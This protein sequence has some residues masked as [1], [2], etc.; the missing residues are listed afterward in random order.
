MENGSSV[1]GGLDHRWSGRSVRWSVIQG[2]MPFSPA[3]VSQSW[4]EASRWTWVRRLTSA[5]AR[6][7]ARA[8]SVAR[9]PA[10]MT[11]EPLGSS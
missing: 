8:L 3:Q 9:L 6:G 7:R 2:W 5:E 1:L 11:M 4:A 10:P